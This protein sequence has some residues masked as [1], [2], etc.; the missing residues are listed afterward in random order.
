VTAAALPFLMAGLVF[1]ARGR[2]LLRTL[3]RAHAFDAASAMT[4][5]RP[6]GLTGFWQSRFASEG[7]LQTTADGRW[8]IDL[9]GWRKHRA[10]RRRRGLTIVAC[11]VVAILLAVVFLR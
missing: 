3:R 1:R 8:W 5:E 7:I 10:A 11:M 6:S 4:M 9:E 2:R